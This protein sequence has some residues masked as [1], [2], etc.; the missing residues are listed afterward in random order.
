MDTKK[1][2]QLL[3]LNEIIVY[4]NHLD[5]INISCTCKSI[6]EY[7][8]PIVFSKLI[9]LESYSI[10]RNSASYGWFIEKC[11]Q[12]IRQNCKRIKYLISG[13]LFLY[14]S[15]WIRTDLLSNLQVISLEKT[16]VDV[17]T[18]RAIINTPISLHS[19]RLN[20]IKLYLTSRISEKTNYIR[21]PSSLVELTI[22]DVNLYLS[23]LENVDDRIWERSRSLDIC[24]NILFAPE[25]DLSNLKFFCYYNNCFN[26]SLI[27]YILSL[28]FN[29]R[30]LVLKNVILTEKNFKN[31]DKYAK[32]K[33]VSFDSRDIYYARGQ[34]VDKLPKWITEL[35]FNYSYE[36]DIW[37]II[38]L[39]SYGFTNLKKLSIQYNPSPDSMIT[40]ITGLTNLKYLKISGKPYNKDIDNLNFQNISIKEL[41]L[42]HFQYSTM[43]FKVF[44]Q[45]KGLKKISINLNTPMT[46]Y[47][48]YFELCEMLNNWKYYT[49]PNSIQFWNMN[50]I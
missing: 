11:E 18:F 19:L 22:A 7:L 44:N 36:I 26:A 23:D 30:S 24:K 9:V 4:L 20:D 43:N 50:K 31:I 16:K 12:Y 42:T 37:P 40:I 6:N 13:N 27:D 48:T 35:S 28:A 46:N 38:S 25:T 21:L 39:A 32:L 15:R 8:K 49:Y 41:T 3:S 47:Y 29:L 34:N 10:Q 5:I 14:C 1:L 17:H 2:Q 33:R 45:W